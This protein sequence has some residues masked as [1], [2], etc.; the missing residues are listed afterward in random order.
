MSQDDRSRLRHG[1]RGNLNAIKLGLSAL[2]LGLGRAETLEFLE[3]LVQAA[4]KLDEQMAEHDELPRFGRTAGGRA[5]FA[6]ARGDDHELTGA[7][8]VGWRRRPLL[9]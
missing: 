9:R 5:G 8:S 3:Y 1:I 2:E 4:E 7:I 6:S